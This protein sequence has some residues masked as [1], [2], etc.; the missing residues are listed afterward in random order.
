[1]QGLVDIII[2]SVSR[3]MP[4]I[5]MNLSNGLTSVPDLCAY[6]VL[7]VDAYVGT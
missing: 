4:H 7:L 1:M 3:T 5:E 2:T 6:L